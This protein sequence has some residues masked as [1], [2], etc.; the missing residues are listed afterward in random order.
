MNHVHYDNPDPNPKEPSIIK[1]AVNK[2][3]GREPAKPDPRRQ[4]DFEVRCVF[5]HQLRP[6]GSP[7]DGDT[8]EIKMR[9][10]HF[11]IY[12]VEFLRNWPGHTGQRDWKFWFQGYSYVT[13]NL[14][15]DNANCYVHKNK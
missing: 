9:S 11:G 3:L 14:N 13:D 5:D 12:K 6:Y 15:F 4:M 2:I 8:V 10:G 1:R 7:K